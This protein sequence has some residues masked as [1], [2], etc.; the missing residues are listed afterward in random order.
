MELFLPKCW[1]GSIGVW[2]TGAQGLGGWNLD[3]Q[4]TYEFF[5]KTLY[6][7]D[8]SRRSIESIGPVID[9]MAGGGFAPP[10]D[11]GDGGLATDA[12]LATPHQ[13]V[14]APDGSFYI[15]DTNHCRIRRVDRDGTISTIAGTTCGFGGD[16]GLATEAQLNYPE[17]IALSPD[18]SL[19]IADTRNNRVRRV[20]PDAT[21]ASAGYLRME[22]LT[23]LPVGARQGHPITATAARLLRPSFIDPGVSKFRQQVICTSDKTG[24][25][26]R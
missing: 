2:D 7:G 1:H 24:S 19:Y 25:S 17:G 9:T 15:A 16:G 23:Q 21:I 4:H 6:L 11:W 10:P 20:S 14:A 3:V 18:G 5:G 12:Q 26:A 13:V 22:P 8:G